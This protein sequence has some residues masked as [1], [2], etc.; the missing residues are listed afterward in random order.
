MSAELF[1]RLKQEL[2]SLDEASNLTMTAVFMLPKALTKLLSWVIRQ[3]RVSLQDLATYF[4]QTIETT[5]P[6]IASLVEK[7]FIEQVE[8]AGQVV[9][10]VNLGSQK[11]KPTTTPR[12]DPWQGFKE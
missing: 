5:Q 10:Q 3:K 2:E 6:I 4:E 7:K 9:Y 12:K 8:D 1:D 11:S